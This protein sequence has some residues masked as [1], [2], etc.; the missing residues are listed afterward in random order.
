MNSSFNC[1]MCNTEF[2]VKTARE[3]FIVEFC[4]F[5][6]TWGYLRK[7]IPYSPTTANTISV[8]GTKGF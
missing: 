5:C 4:P 2:D 1:I 6:G 7:I 3:G 8:T